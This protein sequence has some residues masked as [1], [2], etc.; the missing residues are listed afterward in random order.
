MRDK[1]PEGEKTVMNEFEIGTTFIYRQSS[2][3]IVTDKNQEKV[4]FELV[5]RTDFTWRSLLTGEQAAP[6]AVSP[7]QL[8]GTVSTSIP[9]T[10]LLTVEGICTKSDELQGFTDKFFAAVDGDIV[11]TVNGVDHNKVSPAEGNLS[12]RLKS[13]LRDLDYGR[14]Q[15][16]GGVTNTV[17]DFIVQREAFRLRRK[18]ANSNGLLKALLEG[19]NDPWEKLL[20]GSPITTRNIVR[21]VLI[22]ASLLVSVELQI[23]VES[24]RQM[25]CERAV[26]RVHRIGNAIL[27]ELSILN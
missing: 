15:N 18:G 27:D 25:V 8:R 1:T 20:M 9:L 6:A 23:P 17:I 16:L 22:E 5:S 12:I 14:F 11:S 13:H 24:S 26:A 4:W 19:E 21:D 10:A 2:L 7:H 3:G